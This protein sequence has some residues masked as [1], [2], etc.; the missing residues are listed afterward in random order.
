[1]CNSENLESEL[2]GKHKIDSVLDVIRECIRLDKYRYTAHG[3]LRRNQRQIPLP[4]ILH[5]LNHG[6]HEKAKDKYD[7]LFKAWNYAIRGATL[8]GN[9]IRVIVSFD[10]DRD[11]LIITTFYLE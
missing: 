4:E 7:E 1:M 9:Q 5:V 11:L 10:E 2:P 8:S 3:Q 6:Y